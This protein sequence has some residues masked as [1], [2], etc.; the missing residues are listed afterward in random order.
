MSKLLTR[1]DL[2]RGAALAGA[3]LALA[4]CQPKPAAQPTAAPAAK[5]AETKPV[6]AQP[7]PAAKPAITLRLGKFAGEAWDFDVLWSKKFEQEHPGITVAVEDVV[8]G[9]MFKKALALAATGTVWD[10]F[11]GHARWQPYLAFKGLCLELDEFIAKHDIAFDDFFPS[12]IADVR[13]WNDNKLFWLPTVLH[14]A[15]NAIVGFNK[16]LLDGANVKVPAAAEEGDWTM[17]DWE[18]IIRAVGK[19]KDIYGAAVVVN[20][21]L[22]MQQ[23]TRTWS[24]NPEKSVPE[25]WLVGSDGK[26]FQLGEQWPLVKGGFEWYHKLV[27]GGFIPTAAEAAALQG[28]SLFVAGKQASAAFTVGQPETLRPQIG[29]KFEPAYVPWP[30]GPSGHR[31]SCIS[32]NTLS[33]YAKTKYPEEAFLLTARL[34]SK[35]PALYAGTDGKLHCMARRSAWFSEKLWSRPNSGKVMKFAAS[36]LEKGVD[37]YPQLWNLRSVELQDVYA[38]ESAAYFDGKEEWAQ[39]IGHAVKPCQEICDLP[40]P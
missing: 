7:T 33:A 32:Y 11:A 31:G 35:E 8:Y 18:Q 25:S 23:F 15:G 28:T 39:Y 34:T 4:A 12:V 1:R 16:T 2:L 36:W 19:P 13:M 9:E 10:V 6:A 21:V 30:K 26:K 40:R 14:P 3:G 29:D 27:M 5:P 20:N 22:Y 17:D 37:P 24:T 38:Q